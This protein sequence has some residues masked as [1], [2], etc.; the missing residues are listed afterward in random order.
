MSEDRL[1]YGE[2]LCE[3]VDTI[4]SK[5]LENLAYDITKTCIVVDDTYKKQGRYT[6][7]DGAL[8]FEAY[9]TITTLNINDNVLV[10]I[11]N[12]DYNNQKTILNKVIVDEY[13][14]SLGYVSPLSNM[15]KFTDNIINEVTPSALSDGDAFGILANDDTE[16]E[17]LLY[18][19]TS[20]EDYSGFSRLG[21]SANFHTKLN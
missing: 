7:A 3:A 4:I 13:T 10:S 5:K 16:L 8:K 21:I 17:K 6:V 11:P 14:S 2:V 9:S 19:F 20:W 15:L 18:E 12:G 1:D